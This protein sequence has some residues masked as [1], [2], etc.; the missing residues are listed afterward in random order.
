VRVLR[1]AGAGSVPESTGSEAMAK[2][3]MSGADGPPVWTVRLR[4]PQVQRRRSTIG[5][6]KERRP[7]RTMRREP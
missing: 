2:Q 4:T 3:H 6:A 1:K 7:A 5:G